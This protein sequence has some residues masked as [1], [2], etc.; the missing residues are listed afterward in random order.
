MGSETS[1]YHKEKKIKKMI[2]K[3]VVSEIKKSTK[4]KGIKALVKKEKEP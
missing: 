2:L 3:V 4:K 1:Q